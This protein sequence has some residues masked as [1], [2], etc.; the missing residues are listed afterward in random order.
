MAPTPSADDGGPVS[1]TGVLHLPPCTG[2]EQSPIDDEPA[3]SV[4]CATHTRH[5]LGSFD[6]V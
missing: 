4:E 1:A 6:T 3:V 2:T 5:G